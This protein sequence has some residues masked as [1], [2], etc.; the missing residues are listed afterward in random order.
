MSVQTISQLSLSR[1][2][3]L[4]AVMLEEIPPGSVIGLTGTLGAGKTTLVQKVAEAAG[5][6]VTDV[7]SPTFTLLQT[8]QGKVVLHH[9]DAYRVADDDEFIELGVDELFE[10]GSAW[11]LVE[12][13]DRVVDTMPESTIWIDIA[14]VSDSGVPGSDDR[15]VTI[16]SDSPAMQEVAEK[17]AQRINRD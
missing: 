7:T 4:A 11:T 8:Y 10:D 5:I 15:E 14:L 2:S 12:W 13:A 17:I 6:D 16:R 9:L 3:Q 1:V